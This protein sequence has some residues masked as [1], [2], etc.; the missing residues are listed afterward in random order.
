MIPVLTTISFLFRQKLETQRKFQISFGLT[1][2][3]LHSLFTCRN[4]LFSYSLRYSQQHQ[5]SYSN[6]PNTVTDSIEAWCCEIVYLFSCCK[7]QPFLFKIRLQWFNL[8][9]NLNENPHFV[10]NSWK[11]CT[12]YFIFIINIIFRIIDI[13]NKWY[14]LSLL[15]F[16]KYFPC[17]L[18][19]LL[20][21]LSYFCCCRE[22]RKQKMAD[23]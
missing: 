14:K 8:E 21:W 6:A 1:P 2:Q 22:Y 13:K 16:V 10:R 18:T 20:P 11:A 17:Y 9:F 3:Y 7:R 5:A 23:P 12:A 4:D 15:F 19:T